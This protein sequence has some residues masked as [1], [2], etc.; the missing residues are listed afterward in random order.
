[1]TKDG[2]FRVLGITALI[3][4]TDEAVRAAA[5]RLCEYAPGSLRKAVLIPLSKSHE[6]L[7]VVADLI[8]NAVDE[9]VVGVLWFADS[10]YE[11]SVRYQGRLWY[12]VDE[13]IA[14]A[15]EWFLRRGV[16]TDRVYFS[17]FNPAA[18]MFHTSSIDLS[19]VAKQALMEM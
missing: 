11:L 7:T 19:H 12:D 8:I 2:V 18:R 1:M 13:V 9:T 3:H 10:E 6:A 17:V 14:L 4:Q 5:K 16:C 15:S